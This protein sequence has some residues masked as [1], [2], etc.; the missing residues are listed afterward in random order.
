MFIP[1]DGKWWGFCP[2]FE[3]IKAIKAIQEQHP[4]PSLVSRCVFSR[5]PQFP[6]ACA[7]R[8][9]IVVSGCRESSTDT[10]DELVQVLV[11]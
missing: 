2:I 5:G 3:A 7:H 9:M 11:L 1:P 8:Q 4:S 6:S 10:A